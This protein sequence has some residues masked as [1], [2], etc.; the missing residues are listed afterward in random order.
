MKIKITLAIALT[1]L[2]ASISNYA[3]TLP[4]PSTTPIKIVATSPEESGDKE[5]Q[6]G[7]FDAAIASYRQQWASYAAG[8]AEGNV[9]TQ[10]ARERLSEKMGKALSN[11]TKAPTI[12]EETELHALKGAEFVKQAKAPADFEKA[13][14][15]FQ[16]AVNG[17][18]WMF[19]YHFNLA[20]AL[21]SATKYKIALGYAKLAKLLA[22]NDKDRRDA[23]GLRAEI[24][25][26][27]EMADSAA[28]KARQE[29]A[30]AEKAEAERANSPRG[31]AE[32][33]LGILQKRFSGPVSR[34]LICGVKLNQYW[35]CNDA[36]SRGSNWVDST[37]MNAQPPPGRGTV[38]YEIVGRES[39]LIEIKLGDYGWAGDSYR[40]ACGKPNGD[41]PNSITWG[42]CP[43]WNDEMKT[44]EM[45]VIFT[46]GSNERPVV[47]ARESCSSKSPDSCRRAQ[48][49]L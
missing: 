42:A 16:D 47:E 32:A 22:Q 34:L 20:V 39:D 18:P 5:M 28:A 3:Q 9:E 21:K 49:V 26:A 29:K 41:D 48:F 24:E 35:T 15:E 17:A 14:K 8:F 30:A 40:T 4:A 1:S 6:N 11:L 23:L 44:Y 46:I 2:I 27:Q 31:R 43:G 13:V 12:S 7:K 10:G 19:D 45:K 25:A 37:S 33:M 36:E 38:R